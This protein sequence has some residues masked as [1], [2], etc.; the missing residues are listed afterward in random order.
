MN[1]LKETKDILKE[2]G[3]TISDII[4]VQGDSVGMSV[5]TFIRLSDVEYDSG[6][7]APKV[8]E[9]LVVIGEDWWLE[10][11]EY[12]GSE[13]WE[14]KEIPK[15]M[16][17]SDKVYALVIKQSEEDICCGWETLNRLNGFKKEGD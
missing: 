6:Y 16:P 13:W 12:D 15:K 17:I 10:R 2:N 11:H 8:A 1:L 9:D 7:G 5:E 14:Y 3:K 4:A